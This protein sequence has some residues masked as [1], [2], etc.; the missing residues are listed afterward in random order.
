VVCDLF[1]EYNKKLMKKLLVIF[2]LVFIIGA[3]SWSLAQPQFFRAH[4][5]IHAARIIE[6]YRA[7]EDGQFL[8]RWSDN[9]GYGY[10][11]PLFE[12]YAPLPYYVGAALHWLGF[13][14]LTAVKLL[15]LFSAI[16]T[17]WGSY[18]L[19]RRFFGRSGA[20]LTA[21]AITLAPYRAVNLFVRGALSEAWGIM[22]MP[23]VL[24]GILQVVKQEKDG[25]KTLTISLVV[26]M[27]SHNIMTML[28]VPLSLLFAVLF[29]GYRKWIV[30]KNKNSELKTMLCVSGSLLLAVGLSSFYLFPALLEKDLTKVGSIFSGYFHYSH[31]FLYIRQ[32]F[33]L[34]WGYEG[35][36]WGPDDGISFFLGWGQLIGLGLTGLLLLIKVWKSKN[37]RKA[38]GDK[39]VVLSTLLGSLLGLSLFM[40]I[41]KSKPLWDALPGLS[42]AQFPWRFLGV[43]IIFLGLLVGMSASLIKKR[44]RRY[45]WSLLLI[46]TLLL[47]AS[48]FQP[49]EFLDDSEQ[50]Y[51]TDE[52]L[53]QRE[54][55]GILPDYI[56]L[57]MAEELTPPTSLAWCKQDC[58]NQLEILIDKSHENLIKTNFKTD[59]MVEFAVA[60][61]PG[62]KVEIDGHP[63]EKKIGSVGNIAVDVTAGEHLV[64]VRFT[65]SNIRFW[66]DLVSIFSLAVYVYLSLDLKDK[67]KV[68]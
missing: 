8:A 49:K 54:M 37:W 60:D 1:I 26:L 40:T 55:S 11:M 66:S 64:G 67:K 31:H 23:W 50:F 4:D 38:I 32:F 48:F 6:M 2:L 36:A 47:N 34:N 20:V 21:A 42:Y 57:Q 68:I 19:G 17:T 51:Y 29:L 53:I 45:L 9:F 39:K 33:K 25:W 41:L 61:F 59:Q 62:W 52:G 28:F 56:P 16:F 5:Y 30:H 13:E 3:S 63:M 27:L 22:A 35:S 7:L 10:G 58:S 46:V 15:F 24:L 18:K 12:F 14:V 65:S 44:A 43:G